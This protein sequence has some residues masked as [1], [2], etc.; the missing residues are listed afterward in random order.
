MK[1]KI[2]LSD[3]FLPLI[4][5]TL[6]VLG[7]HSIAAAHCD[8]LDGPVIQD[9]QK[10]LQA[11]DVTPVLKWVASKDEKKVREAFTKAIHAQG[12]KHA[13]MEERKFFETLV[14]IHRAGEGFPFTGLKP[15][16]Q[17]EPAIAEAD[18]ALESGSPDALI[19]RIT[20]DVA[21]GIRK[22][23]EA[24]VE[25]YKHKDD[26][27]EEG[28]AFVQAYVTFTHYVER[29]H[30]DAQGSKEGHDEHVHGVRAPKDTGHSVGEHH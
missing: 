2:F 19:K 13:H 23:Y 28:R 25:A 21:A 9:A 10:A 4:M 8:T 6:L 1:E 26:S 18:H 20:A 16:G 11:G 22:R 24:A 29:L 30:Q 27:V 17:V 7:V 15:A 14:K 5:A 3:V 12:K